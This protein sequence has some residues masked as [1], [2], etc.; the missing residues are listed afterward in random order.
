MCLILCDQSQLYGYVHAKAPKGLKGATYKLPF[1]SVGATENL[2]MAATLAKGITILK[3]VAREPEIVDLADLL[4]SMGA[5]IS[6]DG[7][8]T[9]E[10]IGQSNTI[11]PFLDA[12]INI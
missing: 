9:I 3:N 8:K 2:L 12:F 1:A 6:G 11:K 10:I 7:T 5:N 4:R